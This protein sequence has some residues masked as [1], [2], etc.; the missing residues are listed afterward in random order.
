VCDDGSPDSFPTRGTIR[1]RSCALR[2]LGPF[3]AMI[4]RISPGMFA[5]GY[6]RS[7]DAR[8]D[9]GGDALL[10]GKLIIDDVVHLARW[11]TPGDAAREWER[12]A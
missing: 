9:P 8:A 1:E 4:W 2:T 3:L 12:G 10:L 6:W 7:V 11:R 5:E